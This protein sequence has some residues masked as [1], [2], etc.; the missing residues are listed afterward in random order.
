MRP[1]P[2]A[3]GFFLA[4]FRRILY[5]HTSAYLK[6]YVEEAD[7]ARLRA[8]VAQAAI[9]AHL[10]GYAEI[11]AELARVLR[12]KQLSP[13]DHAA[14]L[15]QFERDWKATRQVQTSPPLIRRAGDLAEQYGLRGG[16]GIHLAAAEAIWRTVSEADFRVAAFDDALVRAVRGL[17][18]ALLYP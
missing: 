11:R 16:E 6:L 4:F 15:A 8:S 18:M 1:L 2:K 7:S 12:L 13:E 9:C 17:G 3:T 5:L 10:V 14:L